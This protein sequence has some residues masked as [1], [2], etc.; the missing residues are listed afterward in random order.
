M[1]GERVGFGPE[2]ARGGK[3]FSTGSGGEGARRSPDDAQAGTALGSSASHGITRE[4][5]R[6]RVT[7]P[8]QTQR[9]ERRLRVVPRVE[10]ESVTESESVSGELALAARAGQGGPLAFGHGATVKYTALENEAFTSR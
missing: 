2:P 4:T 7:E 1:W 3:A 6:P 8:P 10:L 5:R 9:E